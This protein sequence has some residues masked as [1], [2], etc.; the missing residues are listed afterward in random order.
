MEKQRSHL[1][2]PKEMAKQFRV[3]KRCALVVEG[4][5]K[6]V[7]LGEKFDPD[8]DELKDADYVTLEIEI[9]EVSKKSDESYEGMVDDEVG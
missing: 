8:D 6:G 9:D 4:K 3:G 5:V 2:V 7:R 1:D